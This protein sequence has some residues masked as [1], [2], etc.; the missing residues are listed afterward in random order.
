MIDYD[1]YISKN[2]KEIKPSG[3]RKF[4][5]VANT[6]KDAIS[7]GVGEP[8]F[9]TP[10]SVRDAAILSI[11]KGYTQ[12]T[13]NAGMLELRE[14]ISKYLNIRYNLHYSAEDEILV[15]VGASEGI[16][17]ALRALVNVGEEV[18]IPEPSYVSYSPC[19]SLCGGIPVPINCTVEDEFKVTPKALLEAI[20]PKTK[21]LIMPYPNNPTGAIMEKNYLEEIAKICI[22]KDIIVISDEIYSELTYDEEH[23]SIASLEGMRERTIVINGFSKAFAMT[24]WRLGYLACPKELLVPM[25]KIH[26]YAIMCAPTASQYA[27]LKALNEAFE[28]DFDAVRTMH[29]EYDKRRRFLVQEFNAMG[30]E[31]FEPKGAFYVFP[32]VS[33]TGMDGETFANNLL[34]AKKVAV[35]PG[36]AFGE[37]GKDF[38]R[39]SYA[40]SMEKLKKATKRIAEYVQE[41][42][43]NK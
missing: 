3:I 7:L 25:Y 35:V 31:C 19:V 22:Q 38:V 16:D 37:N 24:G 1:K 11:K 12:Y 30:L 40:Y 2:A 41:I 5:D 9:V 32:K 33:S 13:S 39:I 15:T 34:K 17:L 6:M 27:G 43:N 23:T 29:D 4:F 26:Q 14:A 21:L 10:W 20:T 8:D 42:K 28:D 18:L 36:S